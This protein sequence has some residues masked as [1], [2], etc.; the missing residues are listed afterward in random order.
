MLLRRLP[1]PGAAH[2]SHSLR[3]PIIA[4]FPA[5]HGAVPVLSPQDAGGG[6]SRQRERSAPSTTRSRA[7]RRSRIFPEWREPAGADA[8][9]ALRTGAAL[10]LA[11]GRGAGARG[12]ALLRVGLLL[13]RAGTLPRTGRALLLWASRWRRMTVSSFTAPI[14]RPRA[15]G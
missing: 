6:H 3:H 12:V 14:R 13:A 15:S 8:A 2:K 4:P 10:M 7:A 1:R 9:M 5:L 11:G